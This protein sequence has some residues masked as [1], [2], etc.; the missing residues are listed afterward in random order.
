ME[1]GAMA[2]LALDRSIALRVKFDGPPPPQ[3]V[4]YFRGPVLSRF[5]GRTWTASERPETFAY[6]RSLSHNDLKVSGDA[7][8]YEVTLEPSRQPW[9]MVLDAA[10]ERPELPGDWRAYLSADLQW[11]SPRPITDL[12]R[13]RATSYPQF[14]YGLLGPYGG[15][16]RTDFSAWLQLPPGFNP[17]TVALAEQLK[18]E[19]PDPTPENLVKAA[20]NRLRTGGYVYTLEPG[21]AGQHSADE[22]WFDTKAGFCEHIASAFVVLMRAAGVPSRVVTGF[23]G[24]EMN[25]VDGYWT[26]RNADAHAWVEIWQAERGWVRVDPTS[27]VAPARIGQFNRLSAPDGVLAGAIGNFS[28]TLLAQLRATWE[29]VNNSWNQWVLNYSQTRQFDMLRNLGF[30]APSWEDLGKVL[31]GLL[32]LAGLAGIAWA[33]WERSRHDPWL[34]LLDQARRRLA[35]AGVNTPPQAP[36]GELRQRIKESSLPEE[37]RRPLDG[38]LLALEQLRYAPTA[39]QAPTLATLARAF[40]QLHW[41]QRKT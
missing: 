25:S 35:Q 31:A 6:A 29:A 37:L 21:V 7:V 41:P 24:G 2:Q 5:D 36:P 40:R 9:V 33:R 10:P 1:V 16:P 39:Q 34:R 26:V 19:L 23:Q 18:R 17:R 22:F 38:W 20:M 15:R 4:M 14:S 11:V 12:L 8:S 13:Y 28:P 27:A 30:S 32:A 3:Q